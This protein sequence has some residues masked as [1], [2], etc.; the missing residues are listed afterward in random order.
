[1][2]ISEVLIKKYLDMKRDLPWRNTRD[3]YLI[4]LSEVILQQTR[5]N[6]GLPYFN[7]FSEAYPNVRQLAEANEDDILRLWQGLGYYSRA[8][9]MHAT[10]KRIVEKFPDHF[11]V[12]YDELIL[13]K[14]IGP[15]TAAAV[16][17]F[18]A[19]EDRA[20]V[21]GNVI[22]VISRFAGITEPVNSTPVRRE[23]ERIA[24]E[25]LQPGTAALHNQ[26]LMEL[27]ALICKPRNPLCHECPLQSACAAFRDGLTDRIPLKTKAAPK[28]ERYLHYY[29]GSEGI[30][31]I[32]K[33]GAGDIWQGLY[34]FPLRETGSPDP[35][36]LP[37]FAGTE[38][39]PQLLQQAKHTLSHQ[40]LHIRFWQ[41]ELQADRL[42]GY[43]AVADS[44]LE[45]YGFPIV[46]RKFSN[47]FIAGKGLL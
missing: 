10:A 1:M 36:P 8:R 2:K 15:Y 28:K 18:A 43:E 47:V 26:A 45:N 32:R 4:W 23:I 44:E 19:N 42:E 40:L 33:R 46:L 38:T 9:N 5:V 20:V 7:A 14:G 35:G 24:A 30:Q 12:T 11:P 41:T 22:R 31:Y 17:S 21:D 6:Q 3:P 16:S 13:L 25:W 29:L 37:S 39:A 34:E 27:G